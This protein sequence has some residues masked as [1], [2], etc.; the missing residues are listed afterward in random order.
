MQGESPS[1]PAASGPLAAPLRRPLTACPA[2][3][4]ELH[5]T[6]ASL[7]LFPASA[8]PALAAEP[9]WA[10]TLPSPEAGGLL[11]ATPAA[12]QLLG[13]D[14]WQAVVLLLK[15]D[16]QGSL[17]L[18]LNRPTHKRMG[19]ARGADG[20]EVPAE[21]RVEC[22][23]QGSSALAAPACPVYTH[24][25]VRAGRWNHRMRH[26]RVATFTRLGF[27]ACRLA[28]RRR[29]AVQLARV[30]G[31][32]RGG[33]LA[34]APAARRPAA[35]AARQPG[36]AL[37]PLPGAQPAGHLASGGRPGAGA[38]ATRGRLT[39]GMLALCRGLVACGARANAGAGGLPRTSGPALRL[40]HAPPRLPAV[41][42]VQGGTLRF[43]SGCCTWGPG[44]LDLQME[45]GA[46]QPAACRWGPRGLGR[47]AP[48]ADEMHAPMPALRRTPRIC[49]FSPPMHGPALTR[50]ASAPAA[51]F[52]AAAPWRSSTPPCWRWA[53]GPR[54]CACW[55]A[56]M[57][58][59]RAS[60]KPRQ[61]C[62]KAG[63]RRPGDAQHDD[64]TNTVA[65]PTLAS[66]RAA[67][68]VPE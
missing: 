29:R 48:A 14:F 54:S 35:A 64:S 30:L 12:H 46:W 23:L 62:R 24:A 34:A 67:S 3:F 5:T 41:R 37:R 16:P 17:G 47:P 42:A 10:H 45:Q 8:D 56:S 57:P 28:G 68:D 55:A 20:L 58:T 19:L 2:R 38:C 66:T 22:P 65:P 25:G 43:F 59:P 50:L 61:L 1:A 11:L 51:S 44:E 40:A 26:C 7:P 52:R 39:E 36:G 60:C 27:C 49:E 31:R 6:H 13:P 4:A 9:A 63:P 15:H 33:G 21:V 53:C 18:V 32:P